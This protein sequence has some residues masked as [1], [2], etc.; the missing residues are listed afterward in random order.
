VSCGIDRAEAIELANEYLRAMPPPSND[1]WVI[2]SVDEHDWGWVVSRVTGRAAGGS[3]AIA[4]LYG[5]GGPYLIDRTSGRVA[6]CGSAHP[7]DHYIAAWQR[8][9]LRDLPRP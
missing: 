9:E 8:G 5:G 7:V 6:M 3:T 4:D 1:V 2:T